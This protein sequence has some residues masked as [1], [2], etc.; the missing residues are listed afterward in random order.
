VPIHFLHTNDLH[1]SLLQSHVD[2]LRAHRTDHTLHLDSG[3]FIKAGNLAIPLKPD[4]A[5]A[6]LHEAGCDFGTLGNRESHPLEAGQKAKL[7]GARHRIL[8]ANMRKKSGELLFEES[9][10]AEIAGLKVGIFGLM[11]PMVT[12]RMS[13][14]ALSA[15]LWDQ[16]IPTAKRLAEELRPKVDLLVAIT[17]I[18]IAQ[19]RKLAAECPEIDLIFGGHSHTVLESPERVGKT[20][21]LQGGSHGKFIGEYVWDGELI[22]G[23]LHPIH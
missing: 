7:A 9:A 10:I 23:K 1:G 21:I 2:F 4:P 18:G 17:H 13:T 16:P 14:A 22:L 12:E 5:W 11:V 15:Y 8:V 3:D 6:L 20:S 19:D